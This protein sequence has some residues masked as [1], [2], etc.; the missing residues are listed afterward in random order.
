VRRRGDASEID[1]QY[2][3]QGRVAV[4]S[5]GEGKVAAHDGQ[6]PAGLDVDAH[7]RQYGSTQVGLEVEGVEDEQVERLQLLIVDLLG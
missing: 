6:G 4:E 2:I 5:A 3:A 1:G 7:A